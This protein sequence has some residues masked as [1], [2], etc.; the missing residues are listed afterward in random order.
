M[1]SHRSHCKETILA[2]PTTLGQVV[3][4][5]R[6]AMC[7][8]HRLWSRN[9]SSEFQDLSSKSRW[10]CS[11][12]IGPNAA[13][14]MC[15]MVKAAGLPHIF[16][17]AQVLVGK[18]AEGSKSLCFTTTACAGSATVNLLA[19]PKII[20]RINEKH[21]RGLMAL[22]NEEQGASKERADW[23]GG[24]TCREAGIRKNTEP[25]NSNSV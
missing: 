6:L 19:G 14:L 13:G 17:V 20:W 2:P 7:Q 9:K 21:L 4:S 22:K 25:L 1:T 12:L 10:I 15:L 24:A 16:I 8:Q 11:R 3:H 23:E 18:G 5:R